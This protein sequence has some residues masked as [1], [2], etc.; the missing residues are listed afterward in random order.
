MNQPVLHNSIDFCQVFRLP[1]GGSTQQQVEES[2]SFV[3]TVTFTPEEGFLIFCQTEGVE[4]ESS[5]QGCVKGQGGITDLYN[6]CRFLLLT[7]RD[8]AS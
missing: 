4:G 6:V 2:A 3:T 7:S 5:F 8:S 1:P